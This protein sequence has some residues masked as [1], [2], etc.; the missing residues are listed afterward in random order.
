MTGSQTGGL[1]NDACAIFKFQTRQISGS[2]V[3]ED[4]TVGRR[5]KV[6][7]PVVA[8]VVIVGVVEGFVALVTITKK[9]I[10][11]GHIITG[12]FFSKKTWMG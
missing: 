1:K 5:E 12:P 7:A 10:F 11:G 3:A 8:V 4:I 2:V 9:G 6:V